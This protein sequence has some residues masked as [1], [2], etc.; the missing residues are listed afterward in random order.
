MNP[1]DEQI[2]PLKLGSLV[3]KAVVGVIVMVAVG[4]FTYYVLVME[5]KVGLGVF[6]VL[7][8]LAMLMLALDPILKMPRSSKFALAISQRGLRVPD[9]RSPLIGRRRDRE[10]LVPWEEIDRILV[11]CFHLGG[12]QSDAVAR[13]MGGTPRTCGSCARP[14]T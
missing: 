5:R 4:A 7:F 9:A 11:V 10:G 8:T 6:F 2:Y 14:G 1:V 12:G 13:A 3:P